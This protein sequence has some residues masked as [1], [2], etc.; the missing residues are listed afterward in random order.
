MLV[1]H[2]HGDA[3]AV[4][5]YFLWHPR[6]ELR[7]DSPLPERVGSERR[8]TARGIAARRR[9][10]IHRVSLVR[11]LRVVLTRPRESIEIPP[12]GGRRDTAHLRREQ[13]FSAKLIG[14]SV[15]SVAAVFC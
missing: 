9:L 7:H 1:Q 12:N 2:G 13:R 11:A 3:D 15:A 14:H 8:G 4:A 6:V 5:Q 10:A